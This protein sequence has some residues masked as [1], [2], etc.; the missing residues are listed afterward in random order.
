MGSDKIGVALVEIQMIVQHLLAF[1]DHDDLFFRKVS[2]VEYRAFSLRESHTTGLAFEHLVAFGIEP[3]LDDVAS[4]SLSI[5]GT[6]IVYSIS[7]LSWTKK[8]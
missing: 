7:L 6:N 5:I 3:F 8:E 4:V 2:V 1:R